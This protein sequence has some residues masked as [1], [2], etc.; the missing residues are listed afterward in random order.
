M[1]NNDADRV[2]GT[3]RLQVYLSRCGVASRRGCE[4]L[5]EEGRVAVNGAT[6]MQQGVKVG[7]ADTVTLDGK[8]LTPDRQFLYIALNK[9]R[10]YICTNSDPEGRPLAI[11]LLGKIAHRHHIYSVGRLDYLSSGLLLFTNDGELARAISHPSSRVEKEYSVETKEHVSEELLGAFKRGIT[12]R[13]VRYSIDRYER[14]GALRLSIV[15]CEGKNRE[16]RNMFESARITVKRIHRVRIDGVSIKAM[17]PAEFRFLSKQE[18]ESLRT[19]ASSRVAP[20][21][22]RNSPGGRGN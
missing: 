22:K 1:E 12:Y 7:P 15:I 16:I 10:A 19:A 8:T 13:G 21:R 11:D 6:V 17:K 18:I 9:P 4:A 20:K 14:K 2:S 3:V 5:I